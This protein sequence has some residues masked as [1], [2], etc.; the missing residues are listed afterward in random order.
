MFQTYIYQ[1]IL[2]ALVFIYHTAAFNDLGLAIILLTFAV[3]VVL[4][5]L[6]Y[7]GARDQALMQRLQPRITAIQREHKDD[8]ERQAKALMAL[9]KEHKLNPFSSILLLIV[10]LPIFFALFRMFSK[11]LDG[12][13]FVSH[14]LFGVVDLS[15]KNLLI[16]VIAAALQFLQ[17]KLS[18]ATKKGAGQQ[19]SAAMVGKV[20]L[21]VGPILTV[22][23][24]MNLPSALGL[25]WLVS[26]LFSVVQQVYIN[27]A[28]DRQAD[29][30]NARKAAGNG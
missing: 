30:G 13:V 18:T 10:Q 7:K 15:A 20:M 29:A 5:P 16:V 14:T 26:T 3:R 22:V 27:R 8:K 17:A 23:V 2:D 25:Y 19:G 4:L 12:G 24:L 21:V 1:P 6:F 28:L 11:G 9:Y